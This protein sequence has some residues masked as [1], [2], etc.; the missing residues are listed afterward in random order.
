M[1]LLE[2]A[3]VDPATSIV[4]RHLVAGVLGVSYSA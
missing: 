3:I 4:L 2:V 1:S